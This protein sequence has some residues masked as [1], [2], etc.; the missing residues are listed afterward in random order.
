MGLSFAK[1]HYQLDDRDA[2]KINNIDES[3]IPEPYLS[4]LSQTK[5]MTHMLSAHMSDRLQLERLNQIIVD[6]K[7][8][9]VIKLQTSQDMPVMLAFIEIFLSVLPEVLAQ[10]VVTGKEPLGRLLQEN[11]IPPNLICEQ[12]Y[13][14]ESDSFLS[15]ELGIREGKKLYGRNSLVRSQDGMLIANS[16]EVLSP[17]ILG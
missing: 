8:L 6:Q 16:F 15:K 9:R 10:A 11:N 12:L 13:H 4:L 7:L 17:A 5:Y 14:I 2:L 1:R 3:S